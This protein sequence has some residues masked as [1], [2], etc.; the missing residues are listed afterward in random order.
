MFQQLKILRLEEQPHDLQIT[1]QF[2]PKVAYI[3]PGDIFKMSDWHKF[4]RNHIL[5]GNGTQGIPV[6]P[7]MCDSSTLFM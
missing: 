3:F 1:R 4:K 2:S 7:A 5:Y 6:P